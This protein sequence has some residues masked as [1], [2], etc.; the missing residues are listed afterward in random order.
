VARKRNAPPQDSQAVISIKVTRETY[1]AIQAIAAEEYRPL[2]AEVRRL[3]E[4][5]IE[6]RRAA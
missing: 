3:I 1:D 4:E 5:H 2:A 6:Q